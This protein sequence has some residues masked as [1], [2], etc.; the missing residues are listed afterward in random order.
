V[1]NRDDMIKLV[2]VPETALTDD[3]IAGL[4]TEAPAAPWRTA[5]RAV[6]WL[7]APSRAAWEVA[8]PVGRAATVLGGFVSYD[9][10]PVG[11]YDEVIGGVGL[12]SGTLTVPFIAVNSAASV[13]GGR[14]NW[15]LPKTLAR[16][17]GAPGTEMTA[18]GT[19]WSVRVTVRSLGFAV[20]FRS[21]GTLVQPWPGGG[22]RRARVRMAG[23]A[24]PALIRVHVT[25]ELAG[26]LRGGWHAGAVLEKATG[27]FG[28]TS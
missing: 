27:E 28:P 19:N 24:R 5:M 23:K 22:T 2:G 4:P 12:L 14:V 17:T 25:G 1:V 15:G 6:V 3:V 18:T 11:P 10:T 9:E 20:P 16:F 13:D 21:R 8:G 7:A 26:W